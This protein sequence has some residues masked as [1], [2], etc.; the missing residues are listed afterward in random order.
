MLGCLLG[1]LGT[2]SAKEQEVHDLGDEID[3][4]V[5]KQTAKEKAVEDQFKT[6][7]GRAAVKEFCSDVTTEDCC[8]RRGTRMPCHKVR[9]RH[10][11]P[12]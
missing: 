10:R 5:F 1:C 2:E 6:K 9:L 11:P 8:R 3:S 7:S 4:I 12:R